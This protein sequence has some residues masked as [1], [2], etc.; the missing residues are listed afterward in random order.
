MFMSRVIEKL[1]LKTYRKTYVRMGTK[2]DIHEK[3]YDFLIRKVGMFLF[4]SRCRAN[5]DFG[6]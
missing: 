6:S 3:S 1:N 5:I 4:T 2:H